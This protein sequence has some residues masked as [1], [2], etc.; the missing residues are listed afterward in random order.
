MGRSIII[1]CFAVEPGFTLVIH[2]DTLPQTFLLDTNECRD[3]MCC[4]RWGGMLLDCQQNNMLLRSVSELC[5]FL[6]FSRF[7]C[8]FHFWRALLKWCHVFQTGTHPKLT[9][10]RNINRFRTQVNWCWDT[11]T[12]T[13]ASNAFLKLLNDLKWFKP[14]LHCRPIMYCHVWLDY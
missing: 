7:C 5:V 11:F 3:I 10:V 8:N 14:S 2:W 6:I 4:I 1:S 13:N 12:L 9:T